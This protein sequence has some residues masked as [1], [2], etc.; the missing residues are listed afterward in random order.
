MSDVDAKVKSAKYF[1]GK[2]GYCFGDSITYGVSGGGYIQYIAAKTG[3]TLTNY[4]V[5]GYHSYEM[6]K[7]LT[8]G[9]YGYS[10]G[11]IATCDDYSNCAFV[12]IMIGTNG[13]IPADWEA[14]LDSLPQMQYNHQ[15]KD[16]PFT[17]GDT[18]V[19]NT[20]DYYAL[21]PN[22]I[23]GHLAFAVEW[24]R[25]K[26]PNTK[27]FLIPPTPNSGSTMQ[28]MKEMYLAIGK[29][30]SVQVVNALDNVGMNI[31]NFHDYSDDGIHLNAGGNALWGRYIGNF[32]NEYGKI[33]E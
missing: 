7:C 21:F 27:V 23:V 17:V 13:G 6:L 15:I 5:A 18:T 16:I 4:G 25:Y 9:R 12:T 32:I 14:S 20:D 11:E 8:G 22:N 26:N 31:Q 30:Y 24:I 1:N 2:N 19:S 3:A 33:Y 10:A 29:R 28:D